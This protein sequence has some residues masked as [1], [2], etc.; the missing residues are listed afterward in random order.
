MVLEVAQVTRADLLGGRFNGFSIR[1]LLEQR[2]VHSSHLVFDPKSDDPATHRIFGYPGSR[3]FVA[4]MSRWEYRLGLHAMFQV[5]SFGLPANRLFRRADVVHY[6]VVHD[7]FFSIAA[8]PVLARLKPSI[9]TWHDPWIMTGHCL[10]PMECDRWRIGCGECP[11]L[12]RTFEMKFD[13]TRRAFA[14]K[15]TIVRHSPI[16]IIVASRWM[17]DMARASPMAVG[18]RLHYIPFGVDLSRFKPR[19]QAAA[20]ARFGVLPD[21]VVV[22][23]RGF[24]SPYKGVTELAAALERIQT[25]LCVL[26]LHDSGGFDRLIGRHQVIGLDWTDDEDA[27]I[28][29]YAATDFFVMPSMGEAFGMMAVEAMACGKPVV[30]FEGTALPDV[31]FAPEAGIAVPMRDVQGL[32]D[33]VQHLVDDAPD[34]LRRGK[35]ARELAEQHYSAE[36]YADRLTALYQAVAKGQSNREAVAVPA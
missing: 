23:A 3:T 8:L 26:S 30:V 13:N 36:L 15:R 21:R 10:H 31:T 4:T 18:A 12:T 35:R 17:L 7:G 19:D 33:A 20:K 6:H 5:H 27:L 9:W 2:G 25:P 14:L 22:A 1:H 29:A 11:D 28:D 34:R 16:D 24:I 32:A